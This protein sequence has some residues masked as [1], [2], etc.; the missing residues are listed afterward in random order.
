M[1]EIT[2][3]IQQREMLCLWWILRR[4]K[5]QWKC[6]LWL[7]DLQ[8]CMVTVEDSKKKTR[9]YVQSGKYVG[10]EKKLGRWDKPVYVAV[11]RPIRNSHPWEEPAHPAYH[12]FISP[13]WASSHENSDELGVQSVSDKVERVFQPWQG[14]PLLFLSSS[15]SDKYVLLLPNMIDWTCWKVMESKLNLQYFVVG[16]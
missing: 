14:W 9:R 8:G 13:P 2:R 1:R 15:R 6:L 4:F 16:I 5:G 10:T 7:A 12:L 3:N 11:N